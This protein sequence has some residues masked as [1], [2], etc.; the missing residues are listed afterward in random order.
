M[1]EDQFNEII[2][3]LLLMDN[4]KHR[5]FLTSALK[6]NFKRWKETQKTI[7]IEAIKK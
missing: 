5:E 7:A 4:K 3:P 6:G 1:T 2:K